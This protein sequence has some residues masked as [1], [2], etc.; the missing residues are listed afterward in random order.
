MDIEEM[1]QSPNSM[2]LAQTIQSVCMFLLPAL[3]FSYLCGGSPKVYLKTDKVQNLSFL[4]LAIV[5]IVAI[6]P[7]VNTISYYNHQI[8]L[9]D[10]FASFEQW[11]KGSEQSAEKTVRLL[12]SDKSI[13]GLVFN[14]LVIAVMAGLA[15]EVFFRGCL[16]QIMQKIF[17]NTHVAIWVT[18]VIFSI[19]HFQFY[20]FF[21]RVILGALLGYLFV[22]SGNIWVPVIVHT[23]HNGLNV[24]LAYVF[25]GTPEYEQLE[26]FRLDQNI[27]LFALSLLSTIFI[28][29]FLYKKAIRKDQ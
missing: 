13:T 23:I 20:G 18:A 16:Q 10:S 9:P 21:P 7:V 25:Y 29:H 12:F 6:Q 1:M 11:M 28:I 8:I 27:I 17:L 19:I 22:W 26:N 24:V 4:L 3:A 2:R 15:E 14:L 5:L